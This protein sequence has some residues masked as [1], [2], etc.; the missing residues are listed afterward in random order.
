MLTKFRAKTETA[1]ISYNTPD[2][3]GPSD[4]AGQMI[5]HTW[6]PRL[7][8]D[9]PRPRTWRTRPTRR[10]DPKK[11]SRCTR[12]SSSVWSRRPVREAGPGQGQVVTRPTSRGTSTFRSGRA[13]LWRGQ[14]VASTVPDEARSAGTTEVAVPGFI[15][16]GPIHRAAP[17]ADG[18]GGAGGDADFLH[19]RPR[20]P[21]RSIVSNLG[22]IASQRPEIVKAFREKWGL[23]RPLHEQYFTFVR[24]LSRGEFG[25]VHQHAARD[26]EGPRPVPAGDGRT[27]DGRGLVCPPPRCSARGLRRLSG[28]IVRSTTRPDGL[29]HRRLHPDLLAG[30]G[31]AGAVLRNAPLDGRAAPARPPD[32]RPR[33]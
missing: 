17:G 27:G 8:Y 2:F 16:R 28:E 21:D 13:H 30:D 31:L 15:S 14:E 22:Q 1:V 10:C 26:H 18:R 3:L 4:C 19:R 11:R 25:N 9:S 7:H 5:L 23:D 20:R 33:T 24:N 12:S 29:P 32:E 6:A